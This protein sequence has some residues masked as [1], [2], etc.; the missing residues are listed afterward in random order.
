MK[1][2]KKLISLGVIGT[3]LVVLGLFWQPISELFTQN[4]EEN[5]EISRLLDSL[6]VENQNSPINA[7]STNISLDSISEVDSAKIA[8]EKDLKKAVLGSSNTMKNNYVSDSLVLWQPDPVLVNFQEAKGLE[9]KVHY[10]VKY[11]ESIKIE[12]LTKWESSLGVAV[13]NIFYLSRRN[14]WN[15]PHLNELIKAKSNEILPGKW[16]ES[17]EIIHIELSPVENDQQNHKQSNR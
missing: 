10:R 12:E 11:P 9:G 7:D 4:E 6:R 2:K 1:S 14:Q 13:K 17:V 15:L 16:V 3:I 5:Q 8:L